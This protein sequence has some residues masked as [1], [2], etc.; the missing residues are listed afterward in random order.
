VFSCELM[1]GKSSPVC[2]CGDDMSNGCEM[3]GGCP[4][5]DGIQADTGC[6]EVSVDTLS[7]VSMGAANSAAGQVTLLEA[8]IPPPLPA[9]GAIAPLAFPRIPLLS[10]PTH[11]PAPSRSAA[12]Y[13]ATNRIRI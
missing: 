13:L 5:G 1:D 6:C 4:L 7:D 11:T 9:Y 2:C 3:G 8:P 10:T 12:V